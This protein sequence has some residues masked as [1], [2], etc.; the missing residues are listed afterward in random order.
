MT[1][2]QRLL[3]TLN[4]DL[5]K[6]ILFLSMFSVFSLFV[7][8]LAVSYYIQ[9]QQLIENSLSVNFDYASKI[10]HGTDLQFKTLVKQL[11]YSADI[12]GHS[13]DDPIQLQNEV[14]RLRFQS[15]AFDSVVVIDKEGRFLS[16]APEQLAFDKK[17]INKTYGI[18]LSL[19]KKAPVI[20]HPYYSV[21]NNLIV[22]ISQPIFDNNHNYLGFIGG[23]PYLKKN[24]IIRE[25]LS[26]KYNYQNSYMY[27]LDQ[28]NRIIFHP[29]PKRISET[30]THNTGLA[31]IQAT[32]FGK[33][34]LVNSEG[35]ENLAGFAYVPSTK[36]II[37]S[38]QPTAVLLEQAT[39]IVYKILFGMSIF[40]LVIFF[41]VWRI[42][43]LISN[44]LEQL[45]K[46]ASILN[47]PDIDQKI[48]SIEP[49]Y[50]EVLKF[51]LSLLLSAQ[52]FKKR[53]NEL[54][55]HVNT[56]PLTG[57]YNR[58]GMEVFTQELM[59]TKTQFCVIAIDIDHFKQV[60]DTYGHDKGDLVLQKVAALIQANFRDND[61]C[62]RFGGEEFIVLT[63]STDLNIGYKLAERLRLK[64]E[65]TLVEGIGP[66][67]ISIGLA[68]WPDS[69]V[70]IKAVMKL[71]DENLYQAKAV[72]RN[73]ICM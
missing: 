60:N 42:A 41:I 46:M 61:V 56:D 44:P 27:V 3:S 65:T 73:R 21:R 24:N 43:Y 37:V 17:R 38:Q 4:L 71:A 69:S 9:R 58:R 68:H 59:N 51:R 34:Q 53:I 2:L 48:K 47:T 8:S 28:Y 14:D 10:A 40:Y 13:F 1:I 18:Q 30:V 39:S 15:D 25:L 62:C 49:W 64:L 5:R 32:K 35:K 11:A 23:A 57:F 22:F 55:Y 6:L 20:T 29:D 67:T 63:P 66:I 33:M 12:L 52:N 26:I 7:I 45:A 70:Q 54:N 72:G 36:W 31:Q 50:F 19:D 16:Y